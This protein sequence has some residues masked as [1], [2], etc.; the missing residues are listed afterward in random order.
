MASGLTEPHRRDLSAELTIS[1]R[2]LGEMAAAQR[3][4]PRTGSS[5]VLD[6]LAALAA[7]LLGSRSAQVSLLTDVQTVAGGAGLVPGAVGAQTPLDESLCTVTVASRGPLVVPDTLSD[8]RVANLPPVTTGGIRAYLGVPLIGD[9]GQSIGSLCAFD[10]VSRTWSEADVHVLEQLAASVVSELELAALSEEFEA[11]RARWELAIE[12]AGVGGLDWHLPTGQLTWDERTRELFGYGASQFEHSIESL[13]GRVHGDDLP[14]LTT[15][16]DE[17][18]ADCGAFTCEFRVVRPGGH[19]RW[20][21]ARGRALADANGVAMRILGAAYDTTTM[22]DGEARVSRVLET[23]PAAFFSLDRKWRFTYVNAVAERLLQR[24]RDEL[25]GGELWT[26]FAAAAGTEIERLYRLAMDTG[27]PVEFETYYAP[28]NSWHEIRAWPGPDGLSVYFM[29][30]TGRRVAQEQVAQISERDRLIDQVT[31]ELASTLDAEEAVARLARLVVPALGDFCIA[32][33]VD[34]SRPGPVW[35]RLRDV[36]WWHVD[37]AQRPVLE[38]YAQVRLT[39]LGANSMLAQALATGRPAR[40][41]G[42]IESIIARIE[43]GEAHDLLKVLNPEL[44]TVLPLRAHGRTLG[45]LCL[46]RVS[47]NARVRDAAFDELAASIA[48][49]AGLVLDNARLYG[50]QRRMAEDL[51]RSL[52]TAPPEPDHMQLA[53]RYESAAETAQVGGDWYDAFLQAGGATVLVIGDVIGH[54][55]VSTA[56]MGQVRGLLRGIA[57]TTGASPS[58]VLTR[59]DGAM[60]LL[61]VDTSATAVVA[62]FE[63]TPAEIEQGV[64]R[65]RWSNAGHP[66]PMVINPDGKVVMLATAEADLLLGIDAKVARTETEVTLQRGAT[67]LLYTDGLVERRGQSINEGLDL[68]RQT[69][70]ELAECSLEDLC[71]QVLSRMVPERGEDD[72]ALA[73]VRLHPQDRPRPAEAGE[74]QVPDVV[75]DDPALS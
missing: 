61:Q 27:E 44:V 25:L 60:E 56:A 66:P 51:Q 17:A 67:V 7:R 35:R 74:V 20:V 75:P 64:T 3:L 29:D 39:S 37:S 73:A 5:A 45:L 14:L 69:L 47:G 8:A 72:V 12:A 1:P 4:V 63:Q 16:I 58:E 13:T 31:A 49:R 6:R 59:L 55:S 15:A 30:V 71:D 23:M 68:L 57:A 48:D 46:Y 11:S 53:V 36:G 2:S 21:Q 70:V 50:Q 22:H 26:L 38:R 32:T 41:P 9:D 52:L 18:V 33:L 65:M 43:P 34:A 19:I 42:T 28:L 40:L 10:D 24:S 62:R 54:D